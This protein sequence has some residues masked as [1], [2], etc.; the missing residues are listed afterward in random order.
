VETG[1]GIE[2]GRHVRVLG[3]CKIAVRLGRNRMGNRVLGKPAL[4][5]RVHLHG[6]SVNE[7]SIVLRGSKTMFFCR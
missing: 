3:A 2:D 1:S 4:T 6:V 5:V 7:H